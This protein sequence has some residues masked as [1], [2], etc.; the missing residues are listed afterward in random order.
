MIGQKGFSLPEIM[1]GAGLLGGAALL[2]TTLTKNM[3]KGQVAAETKMEELEL[4][5]VISSTLMVVLEMQLSYV[6]GK[7]GNSEA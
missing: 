4:K 7:F 5:R 6:L 3:N 2:G 1:I